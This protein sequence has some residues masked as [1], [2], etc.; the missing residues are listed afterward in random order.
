[1]SNNK[2]CLDKLWLVEASMACLDRGH[3]LRA[4]GGVSPDD[5]A[6]EDEPAGPTLHARDATGP[7]EKRAAWTGGEPDR[8]GSPSIHD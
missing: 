4:G 5:P 1:M 2:N 6:A 8:P 7:E 3:T